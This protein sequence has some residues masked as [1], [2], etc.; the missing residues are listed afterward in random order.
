MMATIIGYFFI[1]NNMWKI[2]NNNSDGS[3]QQ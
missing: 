2:T 1:T 3:Q